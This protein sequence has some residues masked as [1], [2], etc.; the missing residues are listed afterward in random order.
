MLQY[1]RMLQGCCKVFADFVEIDVFCPFLHILRDVSFQFCA[2][3]DR[4]G[5]LLVK[6]G[7]QFGSHGV[8]E[9]LFGR[10]GTFIG[11]GFKIT[12]QSGCF[13]RI[14]IQGKTHFINHCFDD[15]DRVLLFFSLS[16]YGLHFFQCQFGKLLSGKIFHFYPSLFNRSCLILCPHHSTKNHQDHCKE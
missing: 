4:I 9:C 11:E 13:L 2:V 10:V 5:I 3:I 8:K 16:Q 12:N 14:F 1:D 7:V 15:F 6:L